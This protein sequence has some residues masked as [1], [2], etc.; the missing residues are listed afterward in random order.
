MT[1]AERNRRLKRGQCL[2]C[3]DKAAPRN[4][5]C[6]RCAAHAERKEYIGDAASK[7]TAR[8]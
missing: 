4:D 3:Q 8:L 2:H 7:L 1:R 5:L 6:K